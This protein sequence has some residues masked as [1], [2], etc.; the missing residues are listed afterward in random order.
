[1]KLP[2]VVCTGRVLEPALR[3]DAVAGPDPHALRVLYVAEY[4]VHLW[5]VV[6]VVLADVRNPGPVLRGVEEHREVLLLVPRQLFVS[7]A[8]GV[9]VPSVNPGDVA[10][11]PPLL[12]DEL[13]QGR[14]PEGPAR[15]ER[16]VGPAVLRLL[17]R[18]RVDHADPRAA[19]PGPP[20]DLSRTQLVR[21]C[22]RQ[23]QELHLARLHDLGVQGLEIDEPRSV[24]V[25]PRVQGLQLLG[26]PA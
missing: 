19:H 9:R 2:R 20:V 25:R 7:V 23:D 16:R 4:Q 13:V 18:G 22:Q 8:G 11:P 15:G 1:M 21:H 3:R 5:V 14:V 6:Q 17:R 26:Q 24:T 10:V 12:L